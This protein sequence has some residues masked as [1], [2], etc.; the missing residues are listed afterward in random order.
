MKGQHEPCCYCWIG[1]FF[2][3]SIR[4]IWLSS[5]VCFDW[6]KHVFWITNTILCL[7]FSV[8]NIPSFP[9]NDFQ[10]LWNCNHDCDT[11]E[12]SI[13]RNIN[14]NIIFI[15][16]LIRWWFSLS[17]WTDSMEIRSYS[18]KCGPV[19]GLSCFQC[20]VKVRLWCC[21]SANMMIKHSRRFIY[22]VDRGIYEL[23]VFIVQLTFKY[24][25]I[26]VCLRLRV[27]LHTKYTFE[28]IRTDLA[29]TRK[30]QN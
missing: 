5:T 9:L 17:S 2:G 29:T 4:F 14:N 23:W 16:H 25:S 8:I 15:F 22:I 10:W 11:T 28:W 6:V 18:V 30:R 24:H 19:S 7:P 26:G 3:I 1:L 13:Q 20:L 21:Q 12:I 27:L